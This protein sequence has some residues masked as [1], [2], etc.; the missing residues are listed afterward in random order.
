MESPSPETLAAWD[1]AHVWHPFTQQDEWEAD[2]PPLIIDRAEGVELIDI[3]G[4]RYLDGIS[5]LWTNVH[6]HGH[7]RINEAIRA[8]LDRV[9]HSTLLGLASTPSILLA[10]RLVELTGRELGSDG[11]PLARV[12][13]SDSGSTAVEVALKIAYQAQQQRGERRR[14]KIAA[15]AEAYHGDTLGS[16]SVGG[17]DLFHGIYRPLLFDALRLPCPDRPDEAVEA[18]C[19]ARIEAL[20]AQE[21]EE[22]AAVILEPLVQ[23]A[24][25]MRSHSPAFLRRL[26]ALARQ[27]G[28]LVIADE[29]A[30]GFGRTG[31]MFACQQAG[32]VPDLLCL[33][34]GLTGG[35]LP[36]A[37]TMVSAAIADAF[38]GPY[39]AHRTFFH[40]H[41]YTGN[42]LAC[43]AALASLEIF[44]EETV[45]AG[46]PPKIAALGAAMVALPDAFFGERRQRGLMA[47]ATLLHNRG[48]TARVGHRVCM[49]ARRHGVIVRPL[50]DQVVFMPPLAMTVE[51]IRA[52]VEA[53]GLAAVEVLREG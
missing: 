19:L 26:V 43:A 2:A 1:L 50:G 41:T 48:P 37:A 14:T 45:I 20:L 28:A 16:V 17:I 24:A 34:K 38:R 4:R 39:E 23:G 13:Y 11:A 5:S 53:V 51:Q 9:A 31:T 27:A 30:T 36:L 25:G 40:G 35:T 3:Q 44:E 49:A 42:P 12:F 33:A 32:V 18:D 10:R 52:V 8:Q 7:P 22:L 47:G 21:G 6:G 15:M 29:V 46:L